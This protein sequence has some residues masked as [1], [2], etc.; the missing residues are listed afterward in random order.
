MC[1]K[2]SEICP[3]CKG[4]GAQEHSFFV[5]GFVLCTKCKGS[6]KFPV[7]EGYDPSKEWG[8]DGSEFNF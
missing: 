5:V 3:V 6:G 4:K 2:S 1:G 7:P 8:L